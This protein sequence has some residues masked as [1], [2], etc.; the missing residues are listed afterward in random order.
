[1]SDFYRMLKIGAVYNH[2]IAKEGLTH[3]LADSYQSI[4]VHAAES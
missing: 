2:P 4:L 1:M 3:V